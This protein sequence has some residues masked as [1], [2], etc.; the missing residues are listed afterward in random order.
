MKIGL[1]VISLLFSCSNTQKNN[2]NKVLIFIEFQD[3]FENNAVDLSI[4]NTPIFEEWHLTSSLDIGLTDVS[5]KIE[6]IENE[7]IAIAIRKD[8]IVKKR[9][10]KIENEIRL[11]ILVNNQSNHFVVKLTEGKYVGIN[12]SS[13]DQIKL[14]QSTDPFE[15]D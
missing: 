12:A 7:N 6:Q 13:E 1:I 8:A 3:F 2:Q 4:N 11:D 5:I 10:D 15:Y 14:V 9:L